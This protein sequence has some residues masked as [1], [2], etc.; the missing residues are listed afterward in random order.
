[1][2]LRTRP[3]SV[4]GTGLA[5][6]LLAVA[7]GCGG[8]APS[9]HVERPVVTWFSPN[10]S[11]IVFE[12]GAV[13]QNP[14]FSDGLLLTNNASADLLRPEWR[15]TVPIPALGLGVGDRVPYTST[16]ANATYAQNIGSAGRIAIYFQAGTVI[17]PKSVL[18]VGG[19]PNP[20]SVLVTRTIA[21]CDNDCFTGYVANE[22]LPCRIEEISAERIVIIPDAF[23]QTPIQ[24]L[25]AGQYTVKVD[26]NVTNTDG[27][28]LYPWPA[29]HSFTVGDTDC[30]RPQV[31][32]TYPI[33]GQENVGSGVPVNTSGTPWVDSLREGRTSIFGPASPDIRIFFNEP[34]RSTTVNE[35]TVGV[36]VEGPA[37]AGGG[38]LAPAAGYPMLK[39]EQEAASLPSNGHEIVWRAANLPA[40]VGIPGQAAMPPGKVIRVVVLGEYADLA[41]V[42]AATPVAS[43]IS[44]LS[45]RKLLTNYVFTFKTAEELPLPQNPFPEF[46]VWWS[47][48]DRIGVLDRVNQ[49]DLATYYLAPGSISLP[50]DKNVLVANSDLWCNQA[51]FTGFSP[52]EILIDSRT[53]AF[54]CHTFLY[55]MSSGSNEVMIVD[56]RNS[57]PVAAL[58]TPSPGGIGGQFSTQGA[59]VLAVANRSAN[60]VT[61]FNVG[62]LETGQQQLTG[63]ILQERILPTG[64][65]PTA[66]TVSAPPGGTL[67]EWNRDLGITGPIVPLVMWTEQIDGTLVTYGYGNTAPS[68]R[69]FLGP[70]S[71]PTDVVMTPCFD[72]NPLLVAAVS[73]AGTGPDE[74]KVSYY[75]AGPGC[76]TGISTNARPDILVGTLGGFDGPQ[77]MDSVLAPSG[78]SY[79]FALAEAGANA[80]R[81]SMLASALGQVGT[82][83]VVKSFTDVGS[84]PTSVAHASGY[85]AD[86]NPLAQ[87]L[88]CLRIE[89]TGVCVPQNFRTCWYNG[90]EQAILQPDGSGV[91]ARTLYVCA[92]GEQRIV[93]VDLLTGAR[94]GE[95]EQPGAT[96][97][98]LK[99]VSTQGSQ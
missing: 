46:A 49:E 60:T 17:D 29:F 23:T 8:G 71:V 26:A 43:P 47:A 79:W 64:N 94:K 93:A 19:R 62:Q 37:Q 67:A 95:N 44:D 54:T 78:G 69:M 87:A 9:E 41:S 20:A 75:V 80:N 59:N 84:A 65:S 66:I 72:L 24:P 14:T 36:T 55:V 90:T 13:N 48:T 7:P 1:M 89:N 30:A 51:Y 50:V 10:L 81:V 58:R 5:A 98:Q 97:P 74:G 11:P 31:V 28:R 63:R 99:R 57:L 25:A 4:F 35:T 2:A 18:D 15:A 33:A 56:S 76:Q 34:V 85:A 91:A 40:T 22:I 21:P 77:T 38:P 53:N 45:G 82:P 88:L 92:Q 61:F 16:F 68:Q 96:I 83:R 12:D 39:S 42:C 3:W 6:L 86:A 70:T 52:S 27:D 32:N 73:Q